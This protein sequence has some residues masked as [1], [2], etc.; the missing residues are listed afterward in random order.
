MTIRAA[1]TI[2]LLFSVQSAH[3]K[4]RAQ[5]LRNVVPNNMNL[6][7]IPGGPTDIFKAIK[8]SAP[9]EI[10]QPDILKDFSSEKLLVGGRKGELA[11]LEFGN[12]LTVTKIQSDSDQVPRVRKNVNG[13]GYLLYPD[14]LVSIFDFQQK[15]IVNTAHLPV[16]NANDILF[17]GNTI[18]ATTKD[19]GTLLKIDSLTGTVEK[20]ISAPRPDQSTKVELRHMFLTP[21]GKR[22]VIQ[23][24]RSKITRGPSPRRPTEQIEVEAPIVSLLLVYN[25]EGNSIEKSIQL[26]A[27]EEAKNEKLNGLNVNLPMQHDQLHNQLLITTLGKAQTVIGCGIFTLSLDTLEIVSAIHLDAGE[28]GPML[29][30]ADPLMG[31]VLVHTHTPVK[32]GHLFKIHMKPEGG[33]GEPVAGETLLDKFEGDDTISINSARTL[34]VVP[35]TCVIGLC[36]LGPQLKFTVIRPGESIEFAAYV[37]GETIGFKP[38]WSEFGN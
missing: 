33:V 8:T 17:V 24:G 1:L 30:T 15:K 16:Q 32:S 14:G 26:T 22:I 35:Q 31:V 28:Q 37:K 13:Q 36:I 20:L 10:V 9:T 2:S 38:S 25:I 5:R 19:S 11:M 12:Q 3:S 29:H 18:Y 7:V 23:V 34:V 27:I 6:Q 4:P 21:D